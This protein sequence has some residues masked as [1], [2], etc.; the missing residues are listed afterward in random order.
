M[1][2]QV[3]S[4]L[5]NLKKLQDLKFEI[6]IRSQHHL[7]FHHFGLYTLAT[8][9][10]TIDLGDWYHRLKDQLTIAEIADLIVAQ[11]RL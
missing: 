7:D 9:Q 2:K 3:E 10:Q 4:L 11:Y 5:P 1:D 6:Y 8:Q